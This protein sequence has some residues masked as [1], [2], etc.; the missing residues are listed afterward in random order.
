MKIQTGSY[1][2]CLKKHETVTVLFQFIQIDFNLKI[3]LSKS[4]INKVFFLVQFHNF[5]MMEIT[6]LKKRKKF[7]ICLIFKL[8][9][10]QNN[11]NHYLV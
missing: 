9:K 1:N 4:G 8:R 3:F 6:I 7:T 2:A 5:C 10:L 11:D